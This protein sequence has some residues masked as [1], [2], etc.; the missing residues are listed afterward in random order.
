MTEKRKGGKKKRRKE[1]EQGA[2]NV[3]KDADAMKKEIRPTGLKIRVN[4]LRWVQCIQEE[5]K[6]KEK[7][8]ADGQNCIF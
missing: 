5:R 2:E 8:L 6:S 7:R 3:E 4:E 1:R